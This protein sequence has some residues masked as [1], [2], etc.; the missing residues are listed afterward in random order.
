[1]LSFCLLKV[2]QPAVLLSELLGS[3]AGVFFK[4]FSEV[5]IVLHT[6]ALTHSRYGQIG[7]IEQ[8]YRVLHTLSV[9]IIRERGAGFLFEKCGEIAGIHV[10][11]L[12]VGL[13][14]QIGGEVKVYAGYYVLH[15]LGVVFGGVVLDEEAVFFC[16]VL[17]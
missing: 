10:Q 7:G 4:Y 15:Q 13:E 5:V 12:G 9:Y 17:P 16:H 11:C 6:A 1:M 3:Y 2:V 8:I 14:A